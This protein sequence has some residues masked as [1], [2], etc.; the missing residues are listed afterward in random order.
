MNPRGSPGVGKTSLGEMDIM[1]E[2]IAQLKGQTW[3][4][5]V[6]AF[7]VLVVIGIFTS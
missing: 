6:G 5:M 3:I 4:Y 7:A 1:A 2:K